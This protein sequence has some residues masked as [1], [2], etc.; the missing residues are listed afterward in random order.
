MRIWDINPGYLNSDSLLKEHLKV[1]ETVSVLTSR[2]NRIQS[3]REI[4]RWTGFG[5]ALKK[6]HQIIVA[7]LA[8]RGYADISPVLTRS[9]KGLWPEI[10][11]D[12]LFIQLEM[13][14]E[15]E[16]G[17][18]PL[19]INAQQLWS[20]H[21]YSVLARDHNLYKR[22][23]K[24]VAGMRRNADFS[25]LAVQ[26]TRV[27]EQPPSEGGMRNA[28]QHMWGHVTGEDE[29]SRSDIVERPPGKLL[30]E[31]QHR[32]VETNEPYLMASTALS[33]LMAWMQG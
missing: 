18:I 3:D 17:R 15:N 11:A 32:A 25:D 12:D 5:W 27:L 29:S 14:A 6:R 28:L 31:I 20:Q 7:E 8:L 33:E 13:L 24:K 23:G 9:G 30:K 2:T 21:K 10:N 4:I 22:I 19:P 1:H 26:L 16:S